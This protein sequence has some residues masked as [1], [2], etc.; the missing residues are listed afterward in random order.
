MILEDIDFKL[1]LVVEGHQILDKK[2]EGFR[3]EVD[4]RFNDVDYKFELVFGEL[5]LIRD[6]S[7]PWYFLP[8]A[9]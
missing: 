1:D 2:I 5:R 9:I 6:E 7:S 3:E 8:W 4:G